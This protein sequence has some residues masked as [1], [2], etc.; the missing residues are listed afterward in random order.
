[1]RG[2]K[3][4]T[5]LLLYSLLVG[6]ALSLGFM[7]GDPDLFHCPDPFFNFPFWLQ[8]TSG[9][10]IGGGF[11]VGVVW[12][13]QQMVIGWR[14][15][16]AIRLHVG[17][18]QLFGVIDS[19]LKEREIILLALSSAVAE[20]V[21]FRGLLLPFIGLI[22]SSLIFGSLHYA[23]RSRGMWMWVP[24]AVLMGVFFG[25]LFQTLGTLLGPMVAHFVINYRNLHFINRHDPSLEDAEERGVH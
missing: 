13:S 7:R 22:P 12:I 8:I 4:R 2:D 14:W 1:M 6:F 20:E 15:T 10:A 16:P 25:L 24:L 17:L 3:A 23:P 18:R 9:I 11:G 19:P 21:F 5:A